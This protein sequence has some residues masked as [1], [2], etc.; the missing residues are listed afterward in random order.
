MHERNDGVPS[1]SWP[2]EMVSGLTDA[3]RHA[4]AVHCHGWPEDDG[5]LNAAEG[6]RQSIRLAAAGFACFLESDPDYPE[7]VKQQTLSRQIQLPSADAVYHYARLHGRNTYRLRGNRGSAHVFQVSA[8][9]G[10]CSNLRDYRLI[11]KQDGDT[12]PLLAAGR[13]LDLVLSAKPQPGHWLR[14]PEGECE[15]FIRQYYADWDSERPALLTIEREGATYPPPPPTREAISQRLAMVGDW[16]RTQSG[17]FEKSIRFH[18]STDPAVLPQLPIP[19]AF[20]DNVYLNGH[21]RCA[22]DQAVI[23]EVAP[24]SAVYWGFQLAN[25]QWEAMT[26]HERMTSLNF[27]QARLDSDGGLRIVIS[28]ADPGV[29]NWFDTSGRTLGLLS[30]RYYKASSVPL[31][32]LRTVPIQSIHEHLPSDTPRITAGERQ[33]TLRRRRESAFRRLCGDQ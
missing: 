13:E 22:A 9:N 23:L 30:G 16:L 20:Q 5:E 10:S 7:L 6:V 21:Y 33:A 3:L 18:L 14:L 29:P 25:L 19:E 4:V 27:R 32:T 8:W 2:D 24:P 1:V 28:H 26:Y 31:P 15:I 17:Y 12:H 11:D